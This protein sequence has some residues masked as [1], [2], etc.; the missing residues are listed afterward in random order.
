MGKFIANVAANF[1]SFGL[2]RANGRLDAEMKGMDGFFQLAEIPVFL[3]CWNDPFTIYSF[4]KTVTDYQG[5]YV[6]IDASQYSEHEY[7]VG[8]YKITDEECSFEIEDVNN[9]TEARKMARKM[10]ELAMINEIK[11][12][13]HFRSSRNS[14]FEDGTPMRIK[15]FKIKL[16]SVYEDTSEKKVT[17]TA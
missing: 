9:L 12:G 7:W 16:Q 14:P 11:V 3:P 1:E 6:H 10:I 5:V 13:R 2:F 17:V 8:H 15:S 4:G